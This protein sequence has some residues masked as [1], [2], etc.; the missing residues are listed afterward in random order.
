[1]R[2]AAQVLPIP[3]MLLRVLRVLRVLRILRLL[4]GPSAKELR[5]LIIT[6]ILSFP[7]LANVGSVL[8]LIVFMFAVL[9]VN[10][11]TYVTYGE[12]LTPQRNFESLGNAMLLLFQCLTGDN[13]SGIMGDALV[14]EPF[15][16]RPGGDCGSHA[17]I[18]YFIGFQLLG[19]FVFLNLVVAVIL[20]NFSSLGN[21]KTDL[22]SAQ[23]TPPNP[24]HLHLTPPM[25]SPH[26]NH[27]AP[28][29]RIHTSHSHILFSLHIHTS[30]HTSPSHLH[31]TPP[32]HPSPSTPPLHTSSGP[33]DVQ[34]GMGRIRPGR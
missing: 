15:C 8:A 17:A 6:M 21:V 27:P 25:S 24:S 16:S 20:E 33:R 19:S 31:F 5:T 10:L 12:N 4:K 28:T 30:R 14:D 2:G 32:I 26:H 1:M 3:P 13:W 11:F 29:R 9:G 23:V 18:P 22:V 7:A 34:G